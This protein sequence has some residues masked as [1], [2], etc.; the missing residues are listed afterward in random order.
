MAI[1][2]V[3]RAYGS[4]SREIIRRIMTSLN[5]SLVD[6]KVILN[7]IEES[8][9][10]WH[11]WAKE[12][13]QI[14]PSFWERYD[15]SFRGFGALMQSILLG[16]ALRDNVV[17]KGRGANFLMEG[18]PYAYRIRLVAPKEKR[19]DY[20]TERDSLD[21]DTARFVLERADAEKAGFVYALY[22]KNVNKPKHYDAVF[23]TGEQTVE[24]ITDVIEKTLIE[25]DKL[26]TPEALKVLSMRAVSTKIK[27]KILMDPRLYIPVL[28]VDCT[29][30]DIVL[31]GIVRNSE[32]FKRIAAA[33]RETA[34]E[35]P[36]KV[37]LR[38]RV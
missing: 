29:E 9:V 12:L 25:R 11:T 38:Y 6:K 3:S 36:L 7:H 14:S 13:D 37:E 23:D 8:G 22:A 35:W 31:R 15:R 4:G 5:Y 10:K 21:S 17:L 16:Y 1:L 24:E 19:V 32:Q 33:A 2:T 34:D 26:R 27:A 28:D 20:V 18:I 30:T